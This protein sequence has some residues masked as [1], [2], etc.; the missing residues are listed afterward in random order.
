M[1]ALNLTFFIQLGLFLL[2]VFLMNRIVFRP[3]L[4]IMDERES[5]IQNDERLAVENK[6]EAGQLDDRY[7][8][9]LKSTKRDAIARMHE[10]ERV[11]REERAVKLHQFRLETDEEVARVRE[12]ANRQLVRESSQSEP[13]T[14]EIA[15]ALEDRLLS[16]GLNL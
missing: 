12:E 4:R 9:A 6:S 1:I 5:R 7:Q 15:K 3:L 8:A 13:L 11:A 10:A 14:T 16:A 2:F